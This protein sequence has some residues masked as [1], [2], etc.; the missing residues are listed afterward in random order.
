MTVTRGNTSLVWAAD[1]ETGTFVTAAVEDDGL[2]TVRSAAPG[3]AH[4]EMVF[5]SATWACLKQLVITC[6]E[7]GI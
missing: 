4:Q 5:T 6:I 7:D 1:D 3:W 2:V